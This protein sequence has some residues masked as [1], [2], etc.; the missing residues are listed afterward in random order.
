MA[1][2]MPVMDV[3][4]KDGILVN[5]MP[6]G[7]EERVYEKFR[8]D[9]D[10]GADTALNSLR[11]GKPE[12]GDD[13][14]GKNDPENNRSFSLLNKIK[15]I[16]YEQGHTEKN[17]DPRTHF[18]HIRHLSVLHAFLN[19]PNTFRQNRPSSPA[20]KIRRYRR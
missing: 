2:L 19:L 3:T 1:E 10:F 4:Y 17:I 11:Y 12:N 6:A 8:V 16:K 13:G 5:R 14:Q 7:E 15:G 9:Y 18:L 20:W